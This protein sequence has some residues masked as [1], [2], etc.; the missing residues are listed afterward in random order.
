MTCNLFA[1]PSIPWENVTWR[2]GERYYDLRHQ[3]SSGFPNMRSI[4]GGVALALV[5]DRDISEDERLLEGKRRMF[6]L[7]S[8]ML[9]DKRASS[10]SPPSTSTS[11][12]LE[13]YGKDNQ[14]ISSSPSKTKEQPNPDHREND[15]NDDEDEPPSFRSYR[16]TYHVTL[17]VHATSGTVEKNITVS[18][19]QHLRRAESG[20]DS[21]VEGVLIGRGVKG[22]VGVAGFEFGAGEKIKKGLQKSEEF[23]GVVEASIITCFFLMLG[24]KL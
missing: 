1:Y 2:L 17:Q 8:E 6:G 7:D 13:N 20:G 24:T 19:P 3:M 22:D 23:F 5:A 11:S 4:P 10:S 21:G 12:H 15:H 14:K 9:D 18:D 16:E